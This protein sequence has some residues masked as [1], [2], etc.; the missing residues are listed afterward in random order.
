[1]HRR[2]TRGEALGFV[3]RHVSESVALEELED[4]LTALLLHPGDLP[5][6]DGDREI[7]KPL[8]QVLHEA[9]RS[10]VGQEPFWKLKDDRPQLARVLEGLQALAEPV[11][12]TLFV[13]RSQVLEVQVCLR[14]AQLFP[15]V[16]WEAG[17]RRGVLREQG[18]CLGVEDKI[19]G[20]PLD[21]ELRRF[22]SEERRVGKEGGSMS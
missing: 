15:K 14:I 1:D 8:A 10:G 20:G 18:I 2:D 9:I 19:L 3:D 12:D 21:P 11:P 7:R 4:P 22:R 6:L 5:K 17:C 16:L 13:L